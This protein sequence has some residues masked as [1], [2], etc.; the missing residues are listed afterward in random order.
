[1]LNLI[2][3]VSLLALLLQEWDF[4]KATAASPGPFN[5]VIAKHL[6][7]KA[8]HLPSVLATL[9]DNIN[10]GGFVILEELV[11]P[12]GAAVYGLDKSSWEHKDGREFGPCTSVSHWQRMLADAGFTECGLLR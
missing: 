4:N 1:M 7:A 9:Y 10:Y 3:P 11:G 8:G 2:N 5:I 12:L 6:S